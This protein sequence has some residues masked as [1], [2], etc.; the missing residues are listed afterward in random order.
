M[1]KSRIILLSTIL[2][3]ALAMVAGC[4]GGTGKAQPQVGQ[5]QPAM[6]AGDPLTMMKDMGKE[7]QELDRYIEAGQMMDARKAALQI[8]GLADKVMP[9]MTDPALKDRMKT[10]AYDLRDAVN[11]VKTDQT[12]VVAKLK[13]MQEV[14]QQ[15]MGNLQATLHKH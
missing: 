15:A 14:M 5:A 3:L 2:I 9:H 8:T 7:A 11:A 4:G 12:V 1:K 13:T 6:P 10:A